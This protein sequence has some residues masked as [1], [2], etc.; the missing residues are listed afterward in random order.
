MSRIFLKIFF[1]FWLAMVVV[2]GALVVSV[3]LT[4]Q[5]P[6]IGRWREMA[7]DALTVYARAALTI[8][9]RN[10]SP[11]LRRYLRQVEQNTGIRSGLFN[12]A[13]QEV[14]GYAA[15]PEA[16]RLAGETLKSGN[17]EVRVFR[18]RVL[19]AV[20]VQAPGGDYYAMVGEIPRSLAARRVEPGDLI[21]RLL[22][23]VLTGG[24]LCY[25]LA[26]YL[27]APIR[28]LS[29]TAR[30]LAGGDLSARIGDHYANRHD[31]FSDLGREF[32]GM[33]DRIETLLRS[34]RRLLSDISH[35]LRSPLTRLSVALGLARTHSGMAASGYLDRIE[36]EA[37][38][39]D[40]LIGQ[41]LQLARMENGSPQEG[42]QP[43]KLNELIGEV[44]ADAD[45][46]ACSMNRSVRVIREE[47]CVI[48]GYPDYLRSAVE[49][50]VRNAIRYTAENTTVEIRL[51][52]RPA[53]REH[54]VFIS[55]RDHG[56]GVP[57]G[58]L[59]DIFRPF[60]RVSDARERGSGASGL[61]LAIAER[62]VRLHGGRILARNA[63][64]GGLIVEIELGNKE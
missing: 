2:A 14:S 12:G 35:E 43:I 5:T 29:Q 48:K 50:V 6:Q 42:K 19:A 16:V 46:E 39:M 37:G 21:L 11:A 59:E 36:H 24:L 47:E 60:F 18:R 28:R 8:Y 54:K 41:L 44:A 55:V 61:G 3:L 4:Q 17:L 52:V 62:A 45:F 22:A 63:P 23:V 1:W 64:G 56:P 7:G 57:D 53:G 10:G 49:N 27:T 9:E 34:E 13:G 25:G 30:T 38:R 26:R 58:A 32:D 31:E 33:A 51:E 20:R 15:P 40:F